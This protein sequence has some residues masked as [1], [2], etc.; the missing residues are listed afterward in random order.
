[1][2]EVEVAAVEAAGEAWTAGRPSLWRRTQRLAP[3]LS[4]T[5]WSTVLEARRQQRVPS[6][7]YA[8]CR[9]LVACLRPCG[10]C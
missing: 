3:R 5:R 6:V 10:A 7:P 2:E 4:A 1:V 8:A 9:A